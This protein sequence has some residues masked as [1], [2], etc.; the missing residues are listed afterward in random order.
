MWM[1]NGSEV[2]SVWMQLDDGWCCGDTCVGEVDNESVWVKVDDK[3]LS[4][5][6]CMDENG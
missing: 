2:T 1:I 4:A 6:V 5:D 3:W